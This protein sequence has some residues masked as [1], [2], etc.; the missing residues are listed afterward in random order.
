MGR[1]QISWWL[2][3]TV[4][5]LGASATVSADVTLDA[6]R[7]RNTA[8]W[9]AARTLTERV[10]KWTSEAASASGMR[11]DAAG[12][13]TL[14][15]LVATPDGR[16][17]SKP[18]DQSKALAAAIAVPMGGEMDAGT[19]AAIGSEP[20]RRTD[21]ALQSLTGVGQGMSTSAAGAEIRALPWARTF[22]VTRQM[23]P[24]A[25]GWSF[26]LR[27]AEAGP[28]TAAAGGGTWR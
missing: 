21:L 7:S 13:A 26:D 27:T 22:V 12:R 1:R 16:P 9:Q 3:G 28:V 25:A 17:S 6:L 18:A 2:A 8:A 24:V 15:Q 10:F 5:V 14:V 20:N 19:P 11:S 4:F 23:T